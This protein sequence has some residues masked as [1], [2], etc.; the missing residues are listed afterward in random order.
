MI[1]CYNKCIREFQ[2]CYIKYDEITVK[3][4]QAKWP[5]RYMFQENSETIS[6]VMLL[7]SGKLAL[8]SD[9]MLCTGVRKIQPWYQI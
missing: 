4:I 1:S 3:K 9:L 7:A 6:T 5:I 8:I 2:T